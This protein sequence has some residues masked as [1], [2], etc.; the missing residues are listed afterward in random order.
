MSILFKARMR[1]DFIVRYQPSEQSFLRPHHD[2]ADYTLNVALNTRNVDFE[3]GGCNFVRRNCSV[4][5]TKKGWAILHPS[6][7]THKHEGLRTTNGTRYI[8]VNFINV[9]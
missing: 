5:D 6:L 1:L 7:M 3:G 2:A 9:E 4:L 8:L